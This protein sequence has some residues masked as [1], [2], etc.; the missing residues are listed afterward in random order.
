MTRT[1]MSGGGGGGGASARMRN[2]TVVHP[3]APGHSAGPTI[4]LTVV[5]CCTGNCDR[6]ACATAPPCATCGLTAVSA[7]GTHTTTAP[8]PA[9]GNRPSHLV[10]IA[11]SCVLSTRVAVPPE[12]VAA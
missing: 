4:P 2:A 1:G 12:N 11:G 5:T 3:P 7:F 9:L 10:F 8:S 6:T